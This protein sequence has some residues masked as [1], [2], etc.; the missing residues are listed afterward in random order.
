MNI[1]KIE[2]AV[3]SNSNVLHSLMK[4]QV[5]LEKQLQEL[6]KYNNPPVITI[7]GAKRIDF[8]PLNEIIY[9]SADL[10]YT[11]IITEN[12]NS[13]LATKS[14]NE[15]EVVFENYSFFKISKSLL[16]NL[17]QI[18]SYNRK[19]NQVIMKNKDLLDVARRRKSE[20][21][22]AINQ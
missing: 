17:N 22:M 15:F 10:S 11:N 14:I 20:F 9:C 1:T 16:V 19:N 21:L 3:L 7:R 18:H 6:I 2:E 4:V 13:I 12:H 8:I 5:S